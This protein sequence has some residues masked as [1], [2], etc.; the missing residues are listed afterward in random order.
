MRFYFLRLWR[1]I[2]L[3]DEDTWYF[4]IIGT[5]QISYDK[6]MQYGQTDLSLKDTEDIVKILNSKFLE[7]FYELLSKFE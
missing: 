4:E 7:I 3:F 6:I 5:Q 1:F 2:S